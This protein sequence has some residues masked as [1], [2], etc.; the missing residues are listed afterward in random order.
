MKSS[1]LHAVDE[2][3]EK[4]SLKGPPT[5]VRV[6]DIARQPT[7]SGALALCAAAAGLDLEKEVHVPLG[8]D[9]GHWTRMRSGAAGIQWEKLA[10]ICDL[11][12]NDAPLLWMLHQRGYDLHSLRIREDETK[13]ALRVE[14]EKTARLQL[15]LDTLTAS[16]ARGVAA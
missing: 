6:E 9:A 7:L 11:C 12:G 4:L 15:A 2:R 14:Q 13:K 10:A 3:Q 5:D 8:I 1:R 16:F